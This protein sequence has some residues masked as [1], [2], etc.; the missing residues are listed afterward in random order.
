MAGHDHFSHRGA[1]LHTVNWQAAP[2]WRASG[3]PMALQLALLS[4]ARD[5]EATPASPPPNA[6]ITKRRS[7]EKVRR[8][9]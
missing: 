7:T 5:S 4:H 8:Y 1:S 3:A 9:H 2:E 6:S